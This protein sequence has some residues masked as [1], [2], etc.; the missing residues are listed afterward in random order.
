M[1]QIRQ[2]NPDGRFYPYKKEGKSA[3]YCSFSPP[4]GENDIYCGTVVDFDRKIFKRK[5]KIVTFVW[6]EGF[7]ELD[8]ENSEYLKLITSSSNVASASPKLT[9]DFGDAYL[10]WQS[11][12][13]SGLAKVFMSAFPNDTD[14][15]LS[16]VAF[17]L[18]DHCASSYARE[19][20][21][22][23]YASLLYPNAN[24]QS[25]R[26]SEFFAELGQEANLRR[27]FKA[28]HKFLEAKGCSSACVIVDSTGLPN[29]IDLPITAINNHGGVI[30]NEI[31]LAAV[32]DKKSGYPVYFK[33]VAGNIPDVS[34][35]T[36]VREELKQHGIE[37]KDS[38]LDAGYYSV[39]NI[40]ELF[41]LGI[42]FM[43]RLPSN[44]VIYKELAETH[45]QSIAS[46]YSNLVRYRDRDVFMKRVEIDAFEKK[47]FAYCGVDRKRR[48]LEE[49]S[50][51]K[52]ASE[53]KHTVEQ[54]D[55]KRKTL[56]FFVLL[57]SKR[58]ETADVLPHYYDRQE[59]EQI[60]DY[61][62]NDVDM[63]PV[64]THSEMAFRGYF[65]TAFMATIALIAFNRQI[66]K[67]KLC[68][69]AAFHAARLVKCNV[70][71]KNIVPSPANK[72]TNKVLDSLD[73]KLPSS[74][75]VSEHGGQF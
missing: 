56:G 42:D 45:S 39:P 10:F 66:A 20:W 13:M 57:S 73:I 35:L 16:L 2:A 47:C 22:G 32:V 8:E 11:V 29:D 25:Q 58:M 59:V 19:W 75:P 7:K 40:K 26:I 70:Y 27:F 64:R 5:G 38:L 49:N 6:G 72:N 62:K 14:T 69:K 63:L 71:E 4:N 23:S 61:A 53:D 28:Y 68:A 9:L 30:S 51:L 37:M 12:E 65:L 74:I 18:L 46:T 34:T 31:R 36:A 43:I 52:K 44:R 54:M 60:F 24:L 15:L 21:E 41:G 67:S 55:K 33:Y 50:Y 48:H 17:K 3:T 1:K